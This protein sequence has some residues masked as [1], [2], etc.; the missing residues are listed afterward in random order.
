MQLLSD[1]R[2]EFIASCRGNATGWSEVVLNNN[3]SLWKREREQFHEF[4]RMMNGDRQLSLEYSV[5]IPLAYVRMTRVVELETPGQGMT[6]NGVTCQYDDQQMLMTY[7]L[8]EQ[9]LN[10]SAARFI[11]KARS[12]IAQL[13]D[14]SGTEARWKEIVG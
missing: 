12:E 9:Q 5:M 1:Y 4:F 13:I 14:F 8:T 7:T 11:F 3:V 6:A 2:S 10:G